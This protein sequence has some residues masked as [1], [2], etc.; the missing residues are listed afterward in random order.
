MLKGMPE[1]VPAGTWFAIEKGVEITFLG[2]TDENTTCDLCGKADLKSTA[3]LEI[4][5]AVVYY[6]CVCAARALSGKVTGKISAAQV[7]RETEKAHEAQLK[8]A[9]SFDLGLYESE[10]SAAEAARR[11]STDPAAWLLGIDACGQ[12]HAST[13]IAKRWVKFETRDFAAALAWIHANRGEAVA[14]R[15]AELAR[16]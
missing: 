5:G 9:Y 10:R 7:R 3:A 13:K 12:F 15:V 16:R 11:E 6:G 8:C 4:D 14:Q 1:G 2:W